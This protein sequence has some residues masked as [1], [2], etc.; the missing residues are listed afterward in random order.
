VSQLETTINHDT[1]K[2]DSLYAG[3][4]LR[5]CAYLI[6]SIILGIPLSIITMIA[7]MIFFG[8]SDVM[9]MMTYDPAL[10]NQELTDQ[11]VFSLIIAYY[12]T[13]LI[14]SIIGFIA[15]V[16][17]FAGLHASKWQATIG[18]KILGLKVTDVSG[19]RIT[20]WR[21]LGRYAAM[22]FLSGIFLIGYII[23]AFTEKKQSLHDLIASTIVIKGK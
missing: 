4:W 5:F 6:D 10:M 15:G 7:F 11:Q 16:A 14:V 17:Y 13:L 3:F 22:A 23:A 1:A 21:A 9:Y 19:N 12:V 20:F 8:T 18:K 2:E